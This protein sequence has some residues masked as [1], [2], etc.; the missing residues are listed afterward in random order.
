MHQ[1]DL[2][3]RQVFL[4][5]SLEERRRFD[6]QR[7]QANLS[8]DQSPNSLDTFNRKLHFTRLTISL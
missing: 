5:L 3:T 6:G 4:F 7:S 8:I 1:K 2:P